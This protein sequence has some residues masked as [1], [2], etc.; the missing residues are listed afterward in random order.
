MSENG[1]QYMTSDDKLKVV[2]EV[3]DGVAHVVECPD[4]VEVQ[5]KDFDLDD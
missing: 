2:I 4:D 5:I 1:G 3:I